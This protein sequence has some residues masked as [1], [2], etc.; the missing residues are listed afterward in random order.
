MDT[1]YDNADNKG[2]EVPTMSS[3]ML[4]YSEEYTA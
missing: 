4:A 3:M 1:A 2:D